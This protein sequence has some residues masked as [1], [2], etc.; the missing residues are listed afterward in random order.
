M[1]LKHQNGGLAQKRNNMNEEKRESTRLKILWQHESTI[2]L[3]NK[4]V[5]IIKDEQGKPNKVVL[6][7]IDNISK[8][9][10]KIAV[11]KEHA[12]TEKNFTV[13][14]YPPDE[15]GIPPLEFNGEKRWDDVSKQNRIYSTGVKLISD[16]QN[17]KD[18]DSL[19]KSVKENNSTNINCEIIFT[20]SNQK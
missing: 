10:I 18:F 20:E 7:I 9:G 19:I 8:N 3:E 4:K 17:K 15:T 5:W 16:E 6:G 11:K 2:S 13:V 1:I 14:I 12:F